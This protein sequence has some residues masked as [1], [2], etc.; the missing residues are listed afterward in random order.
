MS[1]KQVFEGSRAF[2]MIPPAIARDKELL[3]KPKTIILMGEIISM[4]NVT[5]EFF[6]SNKKIAERLDVSA[7][8]VN[9]YLG[10]LESKKLIERTKIISQENGA[11]V[12]RQIRAGVDLVK[13][14]SHKY[15]SNNRTTNRTVEDTYSSADAEPPIPY[16]EII[17]YLNKKTNQHLRYQ[18]KA[19]QK[20]IRQ[21]FEEG[22]TLEDFK[23]AIDNQAYAWQG[24]RFWKYMRPSTLFQA[25]K[26]DSYVNANDLN[27][28]K[29]P[30][31][32]GYGGEPNIS[33]IPDDDLPF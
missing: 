14:T 19:Y 20:L 25:S 21:R 29:Q 13:P 23:K 18:T 5:G 32:G 30:S 26:F 4:L 3:K 10:I 12:G 17:D 9:E 7:R 24:T 22:A 33:D 16:K 1:E 2:L 31:N 27:Q 8:T 11:I 28:A 15:N 6:M